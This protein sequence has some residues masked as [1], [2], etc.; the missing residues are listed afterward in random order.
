MLLKEIDVDNRPTQ[1]CCTA[2]A[3]FNLYSC[4]VM[5]QWAARMEGV[6]GVG[7]YLG[8]KH[9]GKLSRSTILGIPIM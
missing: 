8:Y 4:L 9:D 2:P 1:E 7:V 3:L 6:K 5:E